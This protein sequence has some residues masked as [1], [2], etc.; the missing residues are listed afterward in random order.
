MNK[1]GKAVETILAS[2][3]YA[4]SASFTFLLFI[5][6]GASSPLFRVLFGVTALVLEGAKAVLWVQGWLLRKW[7][8]VGLA[9]A[10]V[11]LSLG[12]SVGSAFMIVQSGDSGLLENDPRVGELQQAIEAEDRMIATWQSAIEKLPKYLM[13]EAKRYGE[14]I[15]AAVERKRKALEDLAKV[16]SETRTVN[17]SAIFDAIEKGTGIPASGFRFWYLAAIACMI[18]AFALALSYV[19]IK[20]KKEVKFLFDGTLSHLMKN[21]KEALCGFHAKEFTT[22]MKAR[23]MCPN[24]AQRHFGG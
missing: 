13:E 19:A 10:A 7:L 20:Q 1:I 5:E 4:V 2:V 18:E 15:N 17:A 9:C 3:F 21:K 24:C 6:L 8:L 23:R 11:V 12:G 22:E 16:R 14:E